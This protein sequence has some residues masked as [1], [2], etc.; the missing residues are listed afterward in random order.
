MVPKTRD[1]V[2]SRPSKVPVAIFA[3]WASIQ[4]QTVV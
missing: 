1:A 2:G 3:M 4:P